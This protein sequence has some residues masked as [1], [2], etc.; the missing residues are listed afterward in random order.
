M[1]V[2]VV[3]LLLLLFSV[4]FRKRVLWIVGLVLIVFVL[5][6]FSLVLIPKG[7]TRTFAEMS[8]V[9]K[10]GMSHRGRAFAKFKEFLKAL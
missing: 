7:D 1:F 10:N 9:E 6:L 5:T 3:G 8:D 2:A 4:L